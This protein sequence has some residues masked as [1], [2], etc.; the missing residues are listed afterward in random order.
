MRQPIVSIITPVHNTNPEYFKACIESA[1]AQTF[2]DFEF[3]ICDDC[4]DDYIRKIVESYDDERIVYIR[5]EQNMG[6][7]QT[8]N[9]MIDMARGDFLALLDSDD[10]MLP[11]RLEKQV[12]YMKEHPKVGCL[13][14]QATVN[15]ASLYN[16]R[17]QD[18]IKDSKSI[19]K[20]LVYTGCVLCNSS[21]M[22]RKSALDRYNVRYKTNFI[23]AEDY[24]LYCDL[25]GK[26]E[27]GVVDEVLCDY[28]SYDENISHR[29]PSLQKYKASLARYVCMEQY[30]GITIPNIDVLAEFESLTITKDYNKLMQAISA[31]RDILQKSAEK[32]SDEWFFNSERNCYKFICYKTHSFKFQLRMLWSPLRKY[33]G[34]SRFWQIFCFVTRGCF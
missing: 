5:N 2:T 28:R 25:V 12:E 9:R 20:A 32:Y 19:E 10:L 17:N 27:F 29:E 30:L 15:G 33:F 14:T 21:V 7:A 22:L 24:A 13:G 18:E 6:V 31:V 23:P 4:S 1:L 3:L 11:K 16:E 34:Q 8:R 26:I